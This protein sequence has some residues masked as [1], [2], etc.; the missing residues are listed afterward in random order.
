MKALIL[1]S[2][3]G[4]RM[5][6]MTK[7]TPKCMIEINPKSVETIISRQL[8]LFLKNWI[9][10]IVITAWFASD[11]LEEYC[12]NLNLPLNT[13]FIQNPI[14]TETNYIYSIYCAKEELEDDIILMHGDLVFDEKVLNEA[15]NNSWSCM[16]TSSTVPLP[17]K[18]FKA[19]VDNWLIKKIGIEFFENAV[20]AMPLYKLNKEDWMIWLNNIINFCKQWKTKVYAENA[21]NEVSDS[22]KILPLDIKDK[23]CMEIDNKEDL[24]LVKNILLSL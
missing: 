8:N 15:I 1:N 22:C 21:F 7:I 10:D 20:T 3:L 16:V 2:G 9:K 12:N 11:L 5:W 4:T 23:F 14:Y 18:D 19:V 24:E 13:K 17:E 6:E